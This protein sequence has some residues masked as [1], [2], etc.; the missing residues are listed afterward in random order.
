MKILITGSNGML[1]KA[2]VNR[3]KDNRLILPSHKDL[4]ISK[5]EDVLNFVNEKRPGIIINCAAY[6]N[7]SKAEKECAIEAYKANIL[8]PSNLAEAARMCHAIM[9][10]FSSDYV[11][12]GGRP[13]LLKYTEKSY[14]CPVNR[15][16]V[17][18]R[19]GDLE[20]QKNTSKY[21]IFRTSWLFGDGNN[22]VDNVIE[23]SKSKSKQ[24]IV[25]DQWGSPTYTVDL[26]NIVYQV[27]KKKLP[28][29]IYNA[30]NLGFTTWYKFA[31]M[32]LPNNNISPI[33]SK[34]F[35][36]NIMRPKNSKLSKRKILKYGIEIPTFENALIRYLEMRK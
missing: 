3:F 35:G 22:F 34:E 30:T 31:K 5:R 16:G 6:T 2:I 25:A 14:T 29:G 11:Y 33:S 28:Y 15:Y 36:G 8:G 20:V 10:H 24:Y 18:K 9:I 4:D 21:Y 23:S 7:T 17:T 1:G 26:A 32:I 13:L 12:G 19:D 27:L